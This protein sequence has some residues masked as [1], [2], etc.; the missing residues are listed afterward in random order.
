L[1]AVPAKYIYFQRRKMKTGKICQSV[2]ATLAV[3]G[4]G[5]A[6][7]LTAHSCA[8]FGVKKTVRIADES[9]LIVW[10]AK[11][12][13]EHLIRSATFD[14]QGN[15]VGFIVP[16]P[17]VPQLAT[18]SSDVFN[19]L[20]KFITPPRNRFF[21]QPLILGRLSKEPPVQIIR[22]QRVG[23]YTAA[24]LRATDADALNQWLKENNY[25]SAPAFQ[26]W[27]AVYVKKGWVLTAFKFMKKDASQSEVTSPLVQMSFRTEQPFFPYREPQEETKNASSESRLLRIY[28]LASGRV[29]PL[30]GH[31]G[32]STHWPGTEQQVYRYPQINKYESLRI[33]RDINLPEATL[34]RNPM[35]TVFDDTSSPRPGMDDVYFTEGH[36]PERHRHIQDE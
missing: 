12:K 21:R 14:S 1:P 24:I 8:S 6:G 25:Q 29:K 36:Q 15:N 22:Q 17:T 11:N 34:N 20:E 32:K 4:A 33:A 13:T 18:A 10:D 9:A 5:A 3:L 19:A 7:T 27:L 28:F 16:T 26:E 35:L 23:N 31:F 30:P 2:V